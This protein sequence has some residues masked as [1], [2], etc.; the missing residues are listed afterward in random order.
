[1]NR[2]RVR[3]LIL[4]LGAAAGLVA[5]ALAGV[6]REPT[7]F[8]PRPVQQRPA[9]LLITSLPLLFADRFSLEAEGAPAIKRLRTRYRLVPISTTDPSEL[10]KGRLLLMAQP[11]AQTAENLVALDAWVR[12][13]GRLLLMADPL[14]EWPSSRPLGD[15]TRPPPVFM[16][17][18]LLK[19]WGLQLEPPDKLGLAQRRLGGYSV[20]TE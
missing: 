2:A 19:H 11:Q 18:G 7:E 5:L 13:G 6:R 10:R 17:T 9:L 1:M 4:S 15:I 14:L 16:D 20:A 8:P 3:A 12:A